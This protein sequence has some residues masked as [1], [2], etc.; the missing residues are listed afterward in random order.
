MR[1]DT[2]NVKGSTS[3]SVEIEGTCVSKNLDETVCFQYEKREEW[4]REERDNKRLQKTG[5][6]LLV[7]PI[8]QLHCSP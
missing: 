5:V 6:G 2:A 1:E 4:I 7:W 8:H 3:L